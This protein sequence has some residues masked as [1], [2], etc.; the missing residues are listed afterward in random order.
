MVETGRIS[1]EE[2]SLQTI[3]D[4]IAGHPGERD[5]ILHHNPSFIFFKWTDTHGAIG[6]LGEELTAGR[7]IAVDQSLSLI[8][9]S[10]P[11]R[12]Y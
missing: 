5:E 3:R 4:Y 11:T 8:H 12:P 9:I 10:E 6:N 7:S 1:L 2:A